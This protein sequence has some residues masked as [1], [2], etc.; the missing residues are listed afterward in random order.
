MT[1][2]EFTLIGAESIRASNGTHVHYIKPWSYL[3]HKRLLD[4]SLTIVALV[5]LS[6]PMLLIAA[7]IKLSS[8]GPIFYRQNRHGLNGHI[9][10]I[11][12]FRTMTCVEDDSNF[13]QAVPGDVRVT[14]VGKILRKASLDE[15]PNLFNVLSGEMSLV[16][17]RPHAVKLEKDL[18]S[19]TSEYPKRSK[20]KPGITGLSQVKGFRGPTDTLERILGRVKYDNQYVDE[21]GIGLDIKILFQTI[22][23]ILKDPMAF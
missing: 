15:L 18:K 1:V 19:C 8:K 4:F 12:K 23:V 2:R 6:V 5:I 21:C 14:S 13:K 16:G 9:F 22:R 11:W 17:P 3:L 20:V 10:K 7:A